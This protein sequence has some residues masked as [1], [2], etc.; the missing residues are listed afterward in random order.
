M[1]NLIASLIYLVEVVEE[2]FSRTPL[3]DAKSVINT[4][5]P[6]PGSCRY[7][8]Q[9]QS[10]V[11]HAKRQEVVVKEALHIQMTPTEVLFNQNGEFKSL[12]DRSQ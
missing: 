3:E 12:V 1:V 9:C 5:C 10:V 4:R 11:D 2:F 8:L 6:Q 7:C